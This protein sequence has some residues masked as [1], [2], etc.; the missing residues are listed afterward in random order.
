[1]HCGRL[2]SDT[3]R[4]WLIGSHEKNYVCFLGYLRRFAECQFT[5]RKN[6]F[7]L[8]LVTQFGDLAFGVVVF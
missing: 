8:F 4:I 6:Q 3:W 1:L 2:L 7:P 5:E